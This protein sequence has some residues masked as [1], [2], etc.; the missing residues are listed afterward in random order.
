MASSTTL[1][2]QSVAMAAP[3]AIAAVGTYPRAVGVWASNDAR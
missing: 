2:R 3:P 1:A